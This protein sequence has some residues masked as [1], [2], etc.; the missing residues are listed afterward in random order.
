MQYQTYFLTVKYSFLFGVVVRQYSAIDQTRQM[1]KLAL[2]AR[3]L[4]ERGRCGE[5]EGGNLQLGKEFSQPEI[6]V[7]DTDTRDTTIKR[8][9]KDLIN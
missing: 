7:R 2:V 3:L 9:R 5:L 8:R 1:M 6:R 4:A